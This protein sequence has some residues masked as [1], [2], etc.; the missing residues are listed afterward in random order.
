MCVFGSWKRAILYIY[1]LCILMQTLNETP[2][3]GVYSMCVCAWRTLVVKVSTLGVRVALP[4]LLE[5]T[6]HK[7]LLHL[8]RHTVP[9]VLILTHTLLLSL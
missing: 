3:E 1:I 5:T 8:T 2:I 9:D 7:K 6:V 4:V